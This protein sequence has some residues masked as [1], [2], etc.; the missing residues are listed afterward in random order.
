VAVKL[1]DVAQEAGVSL[2]T[3]SRAF[4]SADLLAP[5]TRRRVM[6]AAQRVGYDVPT[7]NRVRTIAVLVPDV[8]NAV[9]AAMLKTIQEKTWPGRHRMFLADTGE[10]PGREIEFLQTLGQD[11][12][13]VIL[14][15]PRS[16]PTSAAEAVGTTPLVVVNGEAEQAPVV[17][18]D[19]EQGLRQATEH[20]QSLGHESLVYVP[21]PAASWANRTRS[22]ILTELAAQRGLDLAVVGNQSADVHGGLAA[23]AAVAASGATAVVAYNDLVAMGVQAGIRALGYRCPD[24]ISIVGIDNIDVAAASDPGLTTVKVDIEKSGSLSFSMVM[25]QIDGR[26]V[27]RDPVRLGSQLIVRGSTA[28]PPGPGTSAPA[29][30]ARATRGR[31]PR[32]GPSIGEG[33]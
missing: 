16:D 28:A 14:C 10:D 19:V 29:A 1:K 25:D 20:L 7:P 27:Q 22:R 5:H 24:D 23:A 33:K 15:S 12:D 11:A 18:M 30:E 32:G 9:Y 13:G 26:P 6:E 3:A 21:G 8:S 4:S 17:L 31:R 2:A